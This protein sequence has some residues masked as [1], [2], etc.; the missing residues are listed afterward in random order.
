MMGW[1]G[2]CVHLVEKVVIVVV[3]QPVLHELPTHPHVGHLQRGGGQRRR[4]A[5]LPQQPAHTQHTP[6]AYPP[7]APHWKDG[8][9]L[10]DINVC[11]P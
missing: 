6:A 8:S 1:W 7:H 10:D 3:V 11:L 4:Q 9:A 5:D 2:G